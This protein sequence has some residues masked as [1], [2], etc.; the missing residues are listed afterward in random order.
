MD[1]SPKRLLIALSMVFL[2][3]V[4]FAI[5]NG[6]YA[7]EEGS[8]LPIIV[9][10]ISLVSLV[11]GGSIVIMFQWKINRMQLEKVTK[12]LPPEERRLVTV[13]MQNNNSLEQ[14]K[15]VALTGMNKVKISRL[16]K[17]LENRG[18]LSKTDLG[19]TNLI[20]LEI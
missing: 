16:V 6:L 7:K 2:L 20:V 10:A 5:V 15:I 12:I 13:L 4:M 17:E 3:G 18:V 8:Q 11:L 9:Y 14:N 19:N 1:I